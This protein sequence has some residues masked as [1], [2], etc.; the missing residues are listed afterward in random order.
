MNYQ[1]TRNHRLQASSAAAVLE[2]IAADGGLYIR[3]DLSTMNFDWK[4]LLGED[5][6]TMS[7]RILSALL[8]DIPDMETLVKQGYEGKFET[9]ELT[10]L[11]Q[12]GDRYVLELFRGPTSAFKDVALS[13]L[14]RLITSAKTVCG[15]DDEIV[16]LTATSG[17]TGKAALEG[18]HDVPGTRIIVF[19]P[20]GG[21]STVQ[22]AQMATQEGS[23][24]CVCAVRGNFDDAQTGVKNIFA[25]CQDKDLHGVRLSSANSINIGRLAPQVMYYFRAYAD[26][27]KAGRIR[28][29]DTVHYVVPTGNFGDILAGYFAKL[30][31]LPV[32]KLVCASNANDVLTEFLS[33]GVYDKRRPFH[34]TTSPSMDILVSSNLERMLYLLSD[35][36]DAYVSGLMRQL[37][38]E[39]RYQVTDKM[40]ARLHEIFSCACCDDAQAA[41]VMGRVWREHGYV[42]DPHTAVAWHAADA[43]MEQADGAPVVVLSTASPYKFPAAVLSALGEEPG[44]DE[45]AMMD[46]LSALT[47]TPIP[48]NLATLR[49]KQVRHKDVIDKD[50]MLDYVLGKIQSKKEQK[51]RRK[52][53]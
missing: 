39:G 53:K 30:M 42:C 17:D 49:E 6:L 15:V 46:K 36:D 14:P 52:P 28:V 21:V 51:Y 11:A 13:L 3:D 29:G 12:V 38:D 20:H 10:P 35:G 18:F 23:N 22:Q 47:G 19:Y 40:L 31:G 45:F 16:I 2:G 48:K 33:T 26:L 44:D 4:G 7:A 34:K 8:P 25:A 37:R 27:V 9:D 1:S 50:A 5:S 41:E 43:F 24:V 32:G